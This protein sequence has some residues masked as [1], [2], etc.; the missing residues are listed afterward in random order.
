MDSPNGEIYLLPTVFNGNVIINP[1][2]TVV[3]PEGV[4]IKMQSGKYIEISPS[5]KLIVKGIITYDNSNT[6]IPFFNQY[7]YGIRVIGIPDKSSPGIEAVLNG[8]FPWGNA[9]NNGALIIDGGAIQH[10][11]SAIVSVDGGIVYVN[12][13]VINHYRT[14]GIAFVSE[15]AP[16]QQISSKPTLAIIKNS[17]FQNNQYLDQVHIN[18]TSAISAWYVHGLNISNCEFSN[19]M[20]DPQSGSR[21]IH[22]LQSGCIISNCSFNNFNSSESGMYAIS[23]QKHISSVK[24][25]ITIRNNE[26]VDCKN[27]ILLSGEEL[28]QINNNTFY[29]PN[30]GRYKGIILWG[31]NAFN[32]RNNTFHDYGKSWF[33]N[34]FQSKAIEIESSGDMGNI[35]RSNNFIDCRTAVQIEEDNRGLQ[36]KCNDF[37]ANS[38]SS[39]SNVNS[40]VNNLGIPAN[41][42]GI[43]DQGA[44]I[45]GDNIGRYLPGNLFSQ[46]CLNSFPQECDFMLSPDHPVV[47]YYYYNSPSTTNRT[48]PEHHT[49]N[50]LIPK[51]NSDAELEYISSGC[52]YNFEDLPDII[53]RRNDAQSLMVGLQ[54]YAE[55]DSIY[56]KISYLEDYIEIENANILWHVLQNEEIDSV[57]TFLINNESLQ[58]KLWLAALYIDDG[59]YDSAQIIL[60]QITITDQ[61][62]YHYLNQQ[63]LLKIANHFGAGS[64]YCD[65]NV[66]DLLYFENLAN[67]YSPIA[68]RSAILL[69]IIDS[70]CT[71]NEML[72]SVRNVLPKNKS[73]ANIIIGP[74][75]SSDYINI[76]VNYAGNIYKIINLQ[77]Q[78]VAEGTINSE[79]KLSI[80]ELNEGMY[81]LLIYN[82][83]GS[84]S[85]DKFIK[86]Q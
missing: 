50:L 69:E 48:Y 41:K 23:S 86:A 82:K 49:Q 45:F 54:P 46:A 77:G 63:F 31:S 7:F 67:S 15:G 51:M 20:T 39:S 55:I 8:G 73:K 59:K 34:G 65:F 74:K 53:S 16:P 32:I 4:I 85:S 22:L 47:N 52:A 62:S 70:V 11:R 26:F 29:C 60:N 61:A 3:I 18:G 64:N 66:Q 76:N 6:S 13:A 36:L 57:Y 10:A 37:V 81:Q 33:D 83:D 84:I 40:I 71:S 38:I 27:A 14:F 24:G 2:T 43:S 75:P 72:S 35:L 56:Q 58:S 5:A 17:E 42:R 78:T 9:N 79:N 30:T 80:L 28:T 44:S 25:Y 68:F 12:N 21:G 19:A 1:L